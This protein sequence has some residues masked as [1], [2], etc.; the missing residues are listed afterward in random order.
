[1][2]LAASAAA[3]SPMEFLNDHFPFHQN[4]VEM[5]RCSFAYLNQN[6]CIEK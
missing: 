5:M 1:M 4:I 6:V 3:F 2:C